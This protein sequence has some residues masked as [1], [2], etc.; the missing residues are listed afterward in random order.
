MS[1]AQSPRETMIV[2]ERIDH[3]I[4]HIKPSYL[5]YICITW[6]GSSGNEAKQPNVL[7]RGVLGLMVATCTSL[8]IYGT[9]GVSTLNVHTG[10][11]PKR[12]RSHTLG[13]LGFWVDHDGGACIHF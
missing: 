13:T 7:R 12:R 3:R 5:R 6:P 1:S 9:P 10:G 4:V 8:H 2:A 11:L